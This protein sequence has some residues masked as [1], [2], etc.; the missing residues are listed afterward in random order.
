[1]LLKH[2]RFHG[3]Q[4]G[5]VP[6]ETALP[7]FAD[8]QSAIGFPQYFAEAERYAGSPNPSSSEAAAAGNNAPEP[9]P[10]RAAAASAASSAAAAAAAAAVTGGADA[11]PVD[12]SPGSATS[13]EKEG[14]ISF[15][16]EDD[17]V[18]NS[19]TRSVFLKD[20]SFRAPV[21]LDTSI[22]RLLE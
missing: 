21:A 6:P 13:P 2:W 17:D 1:M 8:I 9:P 19:E 22:K 18:T 4:E 14:S 20:L 15:E 7:S 3:Q 11:A 10:P 5:I 16:D 12:I